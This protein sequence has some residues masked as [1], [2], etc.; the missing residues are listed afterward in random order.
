MGAWT[1]VLHFLAS[2]ITVFPA[3]LKGAGALLES[4]DTCGP[5]GHLIGVF[6]IFA[7]GVIAMSG[8]FVARSLAA[9][10]QTARGRS[11]L[12][13]GLI[14]GLV[15]VAASTQAASCATDNLVPNVEIRPI[16]AL[17][18]TLVAFIGFASAAADELQHSPPH[19]HHDERLRG[20]AFV[21][22]ALFAPLLVF[23]FFI[24]HGRGI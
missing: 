13:A 20:M 11:A 15:I 10:G 8:V 6:W 21:S 7:L 14:L 24:S 19:A 17:A 18:L 3:V 5:P 9:R 4:N 23:E 1:H 2:V 12:V 16:L 22:Y